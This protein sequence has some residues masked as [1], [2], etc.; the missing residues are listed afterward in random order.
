[1]VYQPRA[2]QTAELKDKVNIKYSV[3]L[4]HIEKPE[5]RVL[6]DSREI[7][8]KTINDPNYSKLFSYENNK[9]ITKRDYTFILNWET[10]ADTTKI[11]IPDYSIQFN[12]S[13]IDSGVNEG[14]K[15]VIDLEGRLKDP[16]PEGNPV[17]L[18]NAR[19]LDGKTSVSV[20][21]YE[22]TINAMDNVS[23]D[24]KNVV[25]LEATSYRYWL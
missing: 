11:K 8:S 22:L 1:V 25:E 9:D 24:E 15:E 16:N 14:G 17:F 19:T 7:L 6:K 20:N 2:S 4:E 10:G 3:E 5:L 12:L 21:G 13:G 18:S 23:R